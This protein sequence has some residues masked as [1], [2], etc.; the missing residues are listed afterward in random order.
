MELFLQL[1]GGCFYLSNKILFSLSESKDPVDKNRI[2]QYAWLAYIVGAPAWIILLI[3]KHDWI[4]AAVETGGIPAMLLGLYRSR[5]HRDAHVAVELGVKYATYGF[6]AI[7]LALS[8]HHF[9]GITAL[10]QLLEIGVTIGFLL[11]TYLMTQSNPKGYLFFMLMNI[12]M[13]L[14][15][16]LQEK[17]I[18]M[19]QQLVSLC[20]V[21]YGYRHSMR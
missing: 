8:L 19:L 14:L 15:M 18:L 20:F 13:S 3:G 5:F 7:G 16:G 10:S 1:W 9:G 4:A 11:G 21:I 17:Y 12:S 6:I 2:K